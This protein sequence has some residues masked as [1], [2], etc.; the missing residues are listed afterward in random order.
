MQKN[1]MI[2]GALALLATGAAGFAAGKTT[3]QDPQFNVEPSKQHEMLASLAG[4]YTGKVSGMM[5]ES[6]GSQR[7]ESVLGGLWTVS[8][9][10]I[11]VMGQPVHGIEI[12]GYDTLQEKFVAVWIDSMSTMLMIMEGTYDEDT[13]TLTMRGISTGM[14][15]EK[16]EMVNKTQYKDDGMT[17]TMNIEGMPAPMMTIEYERKE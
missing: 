3:S 4:E 15:G 10:E 14:D 16:A 17:F 7:I 12:L 5:G 2:L 6:D 11:P 1:R 13:K 9:S 8:R